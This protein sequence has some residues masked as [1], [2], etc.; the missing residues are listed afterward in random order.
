[1]EKKK[2]IVLGVILGVIV[3]A[4]VVVALIMSGTLFGRN[5]NGDKIPI[6]TL[7]K[8][9]KDAQKKL[10]QQFKN[11]YGSL[12]NFESVIYKGESGADIYFT[13]AAYISETDVVVIGN[14]Y[15]SDGNDVKSFVK[16]FAKGS[17]EAVWTKEYAENYLKGIAVTDTGDVL[18]VGGGGFYGPAFIIKYNGDGEQLWKRDWKGD[19]AA[20]TVDDEDNYLVVGGNNVV[21]FDHDGKQLWKKS[22]GKEDEVSLLA[23]TQDADLNYIIVGVNP[24]GEQNSEISK[25][26]ALIAKYSKGGEQLWEKKY[27]E[28]ED[29]AFYTVKAL[30]GGGFVVAGSSNTG[31]YN[32]DGIR[33]GSMNGI[34]IKYDSDGN[35]TAK[36]EYDSTA[37]DESFSDIEV[38]SLNGT[39]D[40]IIAV[41]ESYDMDKMTGSIMINA[42]TKALM[43][44]FDGDKVL[45]EH[46]LSG[47]DVSSFKTISLYNKD[48]KNC[49]LVGSIFDDKSRKGGEPFEMFNG[50]SQ[51]L[52]LF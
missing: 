37:P 2:R 20:L 13:D 48:W 29:D 31:V 32:D 10:T 5:T 28:T 51:G 26:Q 45:Y 35:I 22:L 38:V 50:G 24:T 17:D 42:T 40:I 49:L 43:V 8:D 9:F 6:S 19:A 44:V 47:Y 11:I 25:N 23:A 21:K 27:N 39:D 3:L 46:T 14:S 1:M 18:V 12:Y 41:G 30:S 16:R 52:L 36:I 15:N 33:K 4:G 7:K 34:I